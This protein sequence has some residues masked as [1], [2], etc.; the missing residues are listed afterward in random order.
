LGLTGS[1][2]GCKSP[3]S[4]FGGGASTASAGT[5]P[6]A[7]P[8][9]ANPV[10]KAWK[11]T[12]G[13]VSSALTIKPKTV[14]ADDPVSLDSKPAKISANTYIATGRLLESRQ[15]LA[16]AQQ[17][18]EKAVKVE[19]TNLTAL[20]SL[21]RLQDRQARP[22]LAVATYHKALKAHPNSAL[23]Y[24]DLGLCY[25]RKRDLASAVAMLHKAVEIESGKPSYRNNLATV[26]VEAGRAD[27]ALRQLQSVHS[28]AA[29]HY[30]LAYLLNHRGQADLARRH[31]QQAL[32]LDPGLSQAREMLAQI[33]G[34]AAGARDGGIQTQQVGIGQSLASQPQVT[35]PALSTAPQAGPLG[36]GFP[37][38][39]YPPAAETPAQS[40]EP[41]FHIGSEGIETSPADGPS[42]HQ[43]TT[44]Q[45]PAGASINPPASFHMDDTGYEQVLVVTHLVYGKDSDPAP[46]PTGLV[47]D[48]A[49]EDEE[50]ADGPSDGEPVSVKPVTQVPTLQPVAE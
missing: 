33:S 49:A 39:T 5:A 42:V 28:P 10:A 48:E 7:A 31:L 3:A 20:V 35:P 41:V 30:N 27:E 8:A 44:H 23:V 46:I 21:A 14:P 4:M 34:G 43:P 19:P 50:S 18:Y 47:D 45:Y 24:N 11:S 17:E 13:A 15:E 37:A 38:Q 12:T 32:E 9:A 29:A 22:D 25:A 26:L 40:A 16:K 6:A 2:F 36:T 1:I